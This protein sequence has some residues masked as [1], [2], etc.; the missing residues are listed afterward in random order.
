MNFIEKLQTSYKYV[1]ENSS[2]VSINY[3]EIDKLIT[4]INNSK[5]SYWLDSNPYKILDMNTEDII[6]FL[7][8]YHT[9]GDYCFWGE[10][11]WTIQTPN[12]LMDGSYAIMYLIINHYKKNK[13]FE[14]SKEEFKKLLTGNVEIPLLEDRYNNLVILNKFLDNNS[15][16]EIIKDKTTDI[17][18]LEYIVDNL[19]YFNDKSIYKG[20]SIYFYK[21]A[22]LLT[23][24]ILHILE[25]KEEKQVDYSHLI[26]CADYKIPQVMYCYNLLK[27][28]DELSNK[29]DNKIPLLEDSEEEV[30]IRA[31][32]LEVIDY[33][34]NKI[35]KKYDRMNIN[36]F[37]WLLSQNKEEMTKNYHRTL[38]KHY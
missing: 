19:S 13:N 6:N 33:I 31:A 25:T 3:K 4:K 15:F 21:R 7:V 11:K 29:V 17:E 22:Q 2:N 26:G 30:E 36:D 35:D 16:Y 18:L 1:V 37:I 5:V 12:G 23:S 38:T 24:D 14:M 27:Y 28:S 9:I 32:D 20:K 10:P 8:I 34:Y